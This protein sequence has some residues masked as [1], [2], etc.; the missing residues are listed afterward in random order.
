MQTPIVCLYISITILTL[1]FNYVL[2]LNCNFNF[3][4]LVELV[5]TQSIHF[6]LFT[7]PHLSAV[8]P[9]GFGIPPI[10]H[11]HRDTGSH[12]KRDQ[13]AL[14]CALIQSGPELQRGGLGHRKGGLKA[15]GNNGSL[16]PQCRRDIDG[17]KGGRSSQRRVSSLCCSFAL[18][19]TLS[20][21]GGMLYH[22][23]SE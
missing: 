14:L 18:H 7:F 8:F 21:S 16:H 23:L 5:T 17:L 22:K 13:E 6:N 15:E 4:S 3:L 10:R 9:G 1:C 11:S 20:F 12:L 2:L 19:P